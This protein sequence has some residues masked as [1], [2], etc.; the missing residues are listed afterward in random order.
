MCVCGYLDIWMVCVCV[1]VG[2]CLMG[3]CVCVSLIE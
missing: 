3:I 2:R 1:V